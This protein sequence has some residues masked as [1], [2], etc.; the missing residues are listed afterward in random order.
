LNWGRE[1]ERVIEYK[2]LLPHYRAFKRVAEQ[3]VSMSLNG[4]EHAKAAGLNLY[5]FYF[6]AFMYTFLKHSDYF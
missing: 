5:I 6:R 1:N 2:D 3:Y 4:A